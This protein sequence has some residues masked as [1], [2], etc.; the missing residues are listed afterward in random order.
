MFLSNVFQLRVEFS[1][2][3]EVISTERL[4]T[5][6]LGAL[7]TEK[8]LTIKIQAIRDL[9]LSLGEIVSMMNTIFI[10]DSERSPVPEMSQESYLE[11][12]DSSRE[13]TINDRE[14]AMATVITNHNCKKPADRNKECNQLNKRPGGSGDLENSKQR[15]CTYHRC[16]GHSNEDHCCQQQSET[17]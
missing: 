9:D 3:G 2:L 15:W 12:R 8:Y 5:F 7:P 6:I 11:G 10:N 4:T 13:P 14:S 16:N 1:D 17:K